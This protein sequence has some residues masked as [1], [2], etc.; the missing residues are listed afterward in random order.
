MGSYGAGITSRQAREVP[1]QARQLAIL[2]DDLE[3]GAI[4][5]ADQGDVVVPLGDWLLVDAQAGGHARPLGPLPPLDRVLEDRG[6]QGPTA[7]SSACGA[8]SWL[9]IGRALA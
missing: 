8:R 9:Y 5:G 2:P 3:G 1:G 7:S 6:M 4:Q